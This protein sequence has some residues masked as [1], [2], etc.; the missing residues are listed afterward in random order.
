MTA[1]SLLQATDVHHHRARYIPKVDIND[2]V[3][4]YVKVGGLRQDCTTMHRQCKMVSLCVSS[5]RDMTRVRS[6]RVC[7]LVAKQQV[8]K[9]PS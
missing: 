4:S 8:A 3:E 9:Q 7:V 5:E 6:V 1:F 2:R